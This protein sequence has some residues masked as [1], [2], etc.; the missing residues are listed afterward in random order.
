MASLLA[1]ALRTPVTT[2]SE[3][4]G[5]A[6]PWST[7]FGFG[8]GTTTQGRKVNND[9]AL[10]LA[11]VYNAINLIADSQALMP[12]GVWRNADGVR[13]KLQ[14][15][16]A[17]YLIS[18]EPNSDMTA[19]DFDRALMISVL[20]KG[21]GFAGIQRNASSGRVEA[22]HLWHY[23]D[24]DVFRAESDG[25]IWYKY[26]GQVHSAA[27]VI[28]IKGFS[29]DGIRGRSVIH[30]AA[31]SLGVSLGAQEFGSG[32]YADRG[33]QRGVIE[34]DRAVNAPV[35]KALLNGFQL[36]MKSDDATRVAMLDE[37][38]HYK[39]IALSPEQSKFI[40]AYANG[41]SDIARWFGLP[42]HKL[43]D[44]TNANYSNIYQMGL[45]FISEAVAPWARKREQEYNRK[46]FT[47]IERNNGIHVDNDENAL[48]KADLRTQGEFYR[49]AVFSKIMTPNEA[50]QKLG[51]NPMEGGDE[52]LLPVQL[53]TEAQVAANINSNE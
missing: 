14:N 50:R 32:S 23:N 52:L 16:P 8:G 2:R 42:P 51:L 33:L 31:D 38:M 30:H 28:H 49:S 7:F 20:L 26:K 27:D 34:S 5:S 40:D 9:S 17:H 29:L 25:R 22:I 48:L 53:Q 4:I 1:Q 41:V 44:L 18:A 11:A 21:D 39:P 13:T 15:H 45:E 12:T 3:T 19:Y 36:A 37:G 35:K 10:K 24:V 47:P 6:T 43:K 46:L